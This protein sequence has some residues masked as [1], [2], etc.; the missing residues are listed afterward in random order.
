[1]CVAQNKPYD[2]MARE[3]L[4]V[5]G[6]GGLTKHYDLPTGPASLMA[7]EVRVF[8]GRRLD[9]AQCHNHPFENWTQDQFWGMAAFFGSMARL[10]IPLRGLEGLQLV[11]FDAPGGFGERGKGGPI[12]QPRTKREVQ[13]IFLDGRV[14][15]AS[16]MADPR[17]TFAEW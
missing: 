14:L 1:D 2:Q 13:P 17:K 8:L 12:V 5:Q 4:D 15:P 9:C 6:T 10:D 11:L 3:R 7:E 16:Q